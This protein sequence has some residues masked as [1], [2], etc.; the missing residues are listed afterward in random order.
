MRAALCAGLG[1]IYLLMA[2]GVCVT[3][4]PPKPEPP[5]SAVKDVLDRYLKAL[6]DGDRK[7]MAAVADVPWL[8]RDQ[9]I[10]R[11]RAGLE[12]ALERVAGQLPKDSGKRAIETRQ[13]KPRPMQELPKDAG[14]VAYVKRL[15]DV[16][17]TDGWLVEVVNKDDSIFSIRKI[18]IRVKD[19]KAAVVAGPLK[20]N[21]VLPQNR[22]PDVVEKALD[23]AEVY[24][25]YSL[26]PEPKFDANGKKIVVKDEFHGYQVL[27]KT[28][29]KGADV[30]KQLADALRLGAEDNYGSAAGCFHPRHGLRLKAGGKTVDLVLCFECLSVP[31]YLDGDEKPKEGFKTSPG[32]QPAFDAV[33]K[34]AKIALPKQAGE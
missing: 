34:T 20:E 22:I 2:D 17:G 31:V 28:E 15:N 10:I 1:L 16:L 7:A 24:E 30:R 27:G 5:P 18:L 14:Y 6:A 9:Q 8:D 21:Q 32:P 33:L 4:E 13:Y 25:V 29:V 23:A 3:A 26:D 12:K 19:G 11:D